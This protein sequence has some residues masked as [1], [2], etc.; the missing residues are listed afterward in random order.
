MDKMF[1][2][3]RCATQM[4]CKVTFLMMNV[5]KTHILC[6][7]NVTCVRNVLHFIFNIFWHVMMFYIG[8]NVPLIMGIIR[9]MRLWWYQC[10]TTRGRQ[11]C[12]ILQQIFRYFRSLHKKSISFAD[13]FVFLTYKFNSP[14]IIKTF[15]YH[16]YRI[17]S[18]KTSD[19]TK[20]IIIYMSRNIINEV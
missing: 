3:P 11:K 12:I 9:F 8:V 7:P 1:K 15:T 10:K 17:I 6:V 5:K 18:S 2:S 19:N 16:Y 14:S 4:M 20:T 13:I